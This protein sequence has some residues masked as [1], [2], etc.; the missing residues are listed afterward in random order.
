V[1]WA[2]WQYINSM[3]LNKYI[4]SALIQCFITTTIGLQKVLIGKSKLSKPLL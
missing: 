3:K 2:A 1:N 4:T